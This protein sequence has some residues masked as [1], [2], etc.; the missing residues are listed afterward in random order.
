MAEAVTSLL[1]SSQLETLRRHGEERRAATGDVLF[2]VGD[3]RYPFI[4]ILEGEAAIL[5]GAGNE[6]IRHGASGFLGEINLL[7]GQ[8]VYLTAV[9]TEPLR[10]IAVDRDDLRA[11]LFDDAPISD[12]LLATFTAR[13]EALQATT[14][15]GLE[16]IGP[17]SSES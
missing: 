4:A 16:V 8:T 12:L 9:V 17:R 11:L 14:G 1:S 5:D 2:R 13:R 3:R 15:I 10:Y 7:S 6:I